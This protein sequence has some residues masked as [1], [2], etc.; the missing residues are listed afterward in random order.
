MKGTLLYT[1][2]IHTTHIK[3]LSIFDMCRRYAHIHTPYTH[4]SNHMIFFYLLFYYIII[5]IIYYIF[6]LFTVNTVFTVKYLYT[7]HQC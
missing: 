3:I 6:Y 7:F 4:I 2:H 5:I 1:Q